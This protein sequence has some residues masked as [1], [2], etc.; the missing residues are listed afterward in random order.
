MV[1]ISF[2][3]FVR[4]VKIKKNSLIVQAVSK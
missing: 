2:G 3:G 1:F 4:D